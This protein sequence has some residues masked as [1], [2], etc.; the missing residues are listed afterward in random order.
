MIVIQLHGIMMCRPEFGN[1]GWLPLLTNPLTID[2][3]VTESTP[4]NPA[5]EPPVSDMLDRLMQQVHTRALEMPPGSYTTRLIEGGIAKM[6]AK[7][8]EETAE[9]IDAAATTKAPDNSHLIYE[10]CDLIYHLWV[11]L[12]SRG[13]TVD[14]LRYEL[15]RREGVSGLT[16]KQSRPPKSNP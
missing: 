9:V 6:G 14:D 12:G 2:N 11:L 15:A 3:R 10:A 13:I 5:A 8:T 16:E 4:E 1:P 7:I